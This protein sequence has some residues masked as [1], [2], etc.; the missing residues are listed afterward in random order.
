[1]PTH[2][3]D[4]ACRSPL[5]KFLRLGGMGLL[6]MGAMS[7]VFAA[8]DWNRVI[9][10]EISRMPKGGGYATNREAKQALIQAVKPQGNRLRVRPDVATPSFCSSA[11]YLLLLKVLQKTPLSPEAEAA[12]L[13]GSQPDGVGVW[14]RW[15]ANG[16]GTARL[17]YELDAGRN[18][19]R[20]EEAR[21][22]DFMKIFWSKEIGSRERGHLVV[23]LGTETRDGEEVVRFWSSNKPNGYGDKVV[24]RRQ[25]ARAVFSRLERPEN[26]SRAAA[27]PKKDAYLASMLERPSSEVEMRKMCGY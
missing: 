6:W 19:S 22:G 20:F 12:L 16:P 1:M 17:F 2:L 8:T 4:T 21:P 15:N 9:L 25:I 10:D 11:T 18:F 23:F 14:G 5:I 7:T 24:P 3:K 27:L 13:V 26:F